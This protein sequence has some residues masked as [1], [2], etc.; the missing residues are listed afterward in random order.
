MPNQ[1]RHVSKACYEGQNL[2]LTKGG[3]SMVIP[4]KPQRTKMTLISPRADQNKARTC[5]EHDQ[6]MLRNRHQNKGIQDYKESIP[7]QLPHPN[8][9]WVRK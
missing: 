1:P 6:N 8:M 7:L 3:L 2:R 4:T 5:M 9:A